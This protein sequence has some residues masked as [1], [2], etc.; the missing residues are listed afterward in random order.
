MF[1]KDELDEEEFV[2]EEHYLKRGFKRPVIIHRAILGSLERFTAILIEHMAGKWPFWLSPRQAIV[3]PVSEK[4]MEYAERVYL[5]LHQHGYDVE[6]DK[7]NVTLNKKIRN[8]QLAQFNY[9]LV[10]GEEEMSAGAVDVRTRE[11]KRLGKY[12]TDDLVKLFE[13]EYPKESN[14]FNEFYGKAWKPEDFPVKEQ[15]PKQEGEQQPEQKKEEN[16]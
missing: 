9:I 10:V 16:A 11:E 5:Y 14:N 2:W 15:P 13:S 6:L 7:T 12:R 3:C 8:A 4:F 1:P